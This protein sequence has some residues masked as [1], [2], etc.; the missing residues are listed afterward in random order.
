MTSEQKYK[1]ELIVPAKL[2][3]TIME[4][5]EGCGV[6]VKA[7]PYVNGDASRKLP[8]Y[9]GAGGSR[10]ANGQ[11]NKGVKGNDLFLSL[12]PADMRTIEKEFI[13]RGFALSTA[14]AT[15]SWLRSEG[16]ATKD[17]TGVWRKT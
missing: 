11:S 15:G 2:F 4:V 10:F 14:S 6:M 7:E 17:A 12:L 5:L 8:R 13:N 3:G 1:V 9:N 16:K